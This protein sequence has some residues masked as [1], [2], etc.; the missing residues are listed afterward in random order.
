M[1]LA[2]WRSTPTRSVLRHAV[3]LR[4]VRAPTTDAQGNPVGARVPVAG[5]QVATKHER[6]L[7]HEAP[8]LYGFVSLQD[9]SHE[10]DILDPLER[11][12]PRSV[13]VTVVDKR[14]DE[15]RLERGESVFRPIDVVE[16]WL[17]PRPGGR[18]HAAVTRVTGR[19]LGPMGAPE[20]LARV[21]LEAPGQ[22]RITTYTDPQGAFVLVSPD[23]R[24]VLQAP[25]SLDV[26]A[27]QVFVER[28]RFETPA[29]APWYRALPDA[30]D[31]FAQDAA[32]RQAAYLP[33]DLNGQTVSVRVDAR[34]DVDLQIP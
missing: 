8:G 23:E 10:V 32:A 30:F 33:I 14:E 2:R 13:R 25:Q 11:Y 26:F 3:A 31:T 12:L 21:V 1:T 34:V 4:I 15:L 20:A 28:A 19:V 17:Y 24:R 29:G 6:A 22:R 9:G 7:Y 5:L 18:Q 27:R 16:V